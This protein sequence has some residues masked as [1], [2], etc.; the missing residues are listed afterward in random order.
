LLAILCD[1]AISSILSIGGAPEYVFTNESGNILSADNWRRRVWWKLLPRA[2]LRRIR[3]HDTRHT[4][5]TL[6]LTKGDNV[7]DVSKQLGHGSVKLTLDVYNHW[8]AGSKKAEVDGLDDE[9]LNLTETVQ[10]SFN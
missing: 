1:F 5:A 9:A 6:R 4:Y 3:I 7:T 2:K 8:V 10:S